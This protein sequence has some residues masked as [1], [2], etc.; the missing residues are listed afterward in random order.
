MPDPKD[1]PAV[2]SILKEQALQRTAPL[3]DALDKGLEDSF[4]AS[5]PVSVT[6]TAVP[7]GRTDAVEAD[8]VRGDGF[9]ESYPRVDEALRSVATSGSNGDI[10]REEVRALRK[11]AQRLSES[12]GEIASAA[13]RVAKAEAKDY[14]KDIEKQIRKNPLKAVGIVAAIAFVWS[15]TR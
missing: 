11:E 7:A 5:D 15:A 6:L 1:S 2:Q 8:R 13:A 4:P 3:K 9:E 14:W 10:D 12:A